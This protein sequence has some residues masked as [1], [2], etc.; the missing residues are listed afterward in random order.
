MNDFIRTAQKYKTLDGYRGWI[1]K[2]RRIMEILVEVEE[3][4]GKLIGVKARK[5]PPDYEPKTTN[6]HGL[7][8]HTFREF[9]VEVEDYRPE[10]FDRDKEWK[11]I[12]KKMKRKK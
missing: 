6:F 2:I 5:L 8:E 12:K 10:D 7:E 4:E 3:L 11:E 1:V 9:T